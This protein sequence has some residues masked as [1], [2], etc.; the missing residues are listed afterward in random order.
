MSLGREVLEMEQLNDIEKQQLK[1]A[2]I[3]K[4]FGD[5]KKGAWKKQTVAIVASVFAIVSMTAYGMVGGLEFFR[6]ELEPSFIDLITAPMGSVYSE[7]QGIRLEVVGAERVNS[8]ILLYLTMQDV[9]GENRLSV[10]HSPDIE[11][12]MDHQ[13]VS[14]GAKSS[15]R[16]HVDEETNTLYFEVQV[17]V[18]LDDMPDTEMLEVVARRIHDFTPSQD[19]RVQ[20]LVEGEWQME[21]ATSDTYHPTITWT[22]VDLPDQDF[23][24]DSMILN[25]FGV[26][27]LGSH[28]LEQD[29]FELDVRIEVNSERL[30]FF[31]AGGGIGVDDFDFFF[32]VSEPI[33]VEEVTAM[34]FNGYRIE[35]PE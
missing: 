35:V 25:P 33:R 1:N 16:L 23:H 20:T 19:G 31:G 13:E 24:I 2:I 28:G 6:T 4:S 22:D 29:D 32:N 3:E 30:N 34:I 26:H 7:D 15:R 8:V 17:H 27:L 18:D 14:T 9:T 21:V 12:F 10:E 5:R 11:I